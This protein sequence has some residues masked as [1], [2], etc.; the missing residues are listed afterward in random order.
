MSGLL[1][2]LSRLGLGNI[3]NMDLY[4]EAE[5]K[6]VQ[7]E[8]KKEPSQKRIREEDFLFDKSY[9]CPVCYKL[10]KE[11]TVRTGKLRMIG[12]DKDLK[13]LYEQMEPI[14][15]DVVL[16]PRCGYST[17]S[18][19]FGGLTATQIKA[20]RESISA[21]Y[22]AAAAG[23][24]TYTYEEALSRYKLCLANT[25]VKR[26]KASEKAYICLKAG[27]LLRSMGED[28]D[29]S[30]ADYDTKVKEIREQE[31]EFLKNALEGFIAARQSENYPICGMDEITL[32]YLIAVLAMEFEQYDI[33]SRLI[34][35]IL[36]SSL[37]NHRI[38]DKAREIKD[39][40]LVKIREQKA[41]QS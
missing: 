36:G 37:T 16:C 22:Q 1:S 28:L 27:W 19:Y 41:G 18:R 13:P 2:G 8:I 4:A 9:E 5:E 31:K 25:I 14:K 24:T 33:S 30:E 7:K 35:N 21:H 38:K 3:E 12:T 39:E 11:K 34:S 29:A 10:F 26:G 20:V 6:P 40:L 15:Y 23:G 32:E 17:L